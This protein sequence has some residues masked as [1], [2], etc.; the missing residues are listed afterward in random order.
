[1]G[2]LVAEQLSWFPES[3]RYDNYTLSSPVSIQCSKNTVKITEPNIRGSQ[4][5]KRL[6][7]NSARSHLEKKVC[8]IFLAI[9]Q[10]VIRMSVFLGASEC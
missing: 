7:E 10:L 4:V 1:M 5:A 3:T 6:V 9:L 8:L 2:S